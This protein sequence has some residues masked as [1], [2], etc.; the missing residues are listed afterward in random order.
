MKEIQYLPFSYDLYERMM[1]TKIMEKLARVK[2]LKPKPTPFK[3]ISLNGYFDEGNHILVIGKTGSGKTVLQLNQ[4]LDFYDKGFKI[5]HRDL[6]AVE[7]VKL[8]YPVKHGDHVHFVK[9]FNVYIPKKCVFKHPFLEK[10]DRITVN[11]F[12]YKKPYDLA[13]ELV[14]TKEKFNVI[15]FDAFARG[16]ELTAI[17]W[18]GFFDSIIDVLIDTPPNRKTKMLLSVD[19]LNDLVHPQKMALTP[20]HD[21]FRAVFEYDIR[22]IRKHGVKLFCSTHRPNQLTLNVRSQFS[23]IWVKESFGYDLYDFLSK[24]LVHLR[25]LFWRVLRDIIEL[26]PQYAYLFDKK[27]KFNKVP[28]PKLPEFKDLPEYVKSGRVTWEKLVEEKEPDIKRLWVKIYQRSLYYRVKYN[29]NLYREI[30]KD[31]QR[32]KDTVKYH[33][34]LMFEDSTISEFDRDL[35]NLYRQAVKPKKRKRKRS[36]R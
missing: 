1:E 22:K 33:L 31:V 27:N 14:D 35:I 4:L 29:K 7:F 17:F 12:D 26:E 8:I 11:V 19:E 21:Q 2:P 3:K 36:V 32:S 25:E 10:E 13:C 28:I 5:V 20:V 15:L 9:H 23:F 6:E 18:S 16:K 34:D 24:Q 30:G